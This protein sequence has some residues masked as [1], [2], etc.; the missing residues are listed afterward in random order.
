ME[1]TVAYGSPIDVAS[2]VLTV[3]DLQGVTAFYRESIGLDSL[4]ESETE[5]RLGVAG[6]ELLRLVADPSSPRA[7]VTGLFHTAFLLPSRKDLGTALLHLLQT[8][9]PLQG[10][11]DHG[12]S[13][14]IYLEDP[15]GNGI[16]IYADKPLDQ[17]QRD[18]T[19]KPAAKT[20]AMD[21][22]SVLAL[23]EPVE[24]YQLP[25]GT[26]VG[27][28]HLSVQDAIATS[29]AYQAVFPM[30]DKLTMPTASFLAGG[31][32]HHHL[33]VNQWN[34]G[35]DKRQAGQAGLAMVVLKVTSPAVYAKIA[36]QAALAAWPMTE[37]EGEL[38]IEDPLNGIV[39]A[40]KIEEKTV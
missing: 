21:A 23:A 24:H 8:Q 19:G 17:W 34:R 1:K 38:Q 27:H 37:Q 16:E 15:E 26:T 10:A 14:A 30:E 25:V 12:Y 40:I 7:R 20:E 13:E 31:D 2:V 11:S 32:Y 39:F 36:H 29:Q 3:H 6:Q 9:T 33:A 4:Q 28:V 22:D 35:L 18:E 5:A